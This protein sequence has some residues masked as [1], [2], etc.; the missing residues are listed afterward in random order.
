MRMRALLATGAVV[1]IALAAPRSRACGQ[2]SNYGSTLAVLGVAAIGL[3]V[4]D[5]GLSL[6]D[7]ASFGS[8]EPRSAGYG[9]LEVILGGGQL[10]LGITGMNSSNPSSFWT[11]Y[12]IWMGALTVH[13]IWTIIASGAPRTAAPASDPPSIGPQPAL[14]ISLGPTYA[15]VG[16]LAHPGFGLVG[17]F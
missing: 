15:P 13:G 4:T 6:Y 2:G 16:Q 17:R 3:A 5:I 14:Q 10:A 11:G 8:P 12:S 7:L 9:V 1:A